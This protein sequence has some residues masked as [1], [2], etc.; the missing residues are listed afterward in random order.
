MVPVVDG[1]VVERTGRVVVVGGTVVVV[2]PRPSG[3]RTVL[4]TSG[5]VSVWPPKEYTSGNVP[6]SCGSDARAAAM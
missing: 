6:S 5:G 1:T 3:K 4:P 2:V